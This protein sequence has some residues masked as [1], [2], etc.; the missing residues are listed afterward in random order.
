[1][2]QEWCKKP[3]I[4]KKLFNSEPIKLRQKSESGKLSYNLQ[5]EFD[6][7]EHA[8]AVA[9]AE[10]KRTESIAN[11]EAVMADHQKHADACAGVALAHEAVRVLYA[12]WAELEAM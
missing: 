6:G 2:W 7:M 8:I 3:A 9:E 12:R 1:M 11:D 5:R 10:I 4:P